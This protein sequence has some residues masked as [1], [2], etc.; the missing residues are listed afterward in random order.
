MTLDII[1]LIAL[2]LIFDFLNGFHDSANSIATIVSTR[3]L[4]PRLARVIGR[5]KWDKIRT[6]PLAELTLAAI[7]TLEKKQGKWKRVAVFPDGRTPSERWWGT[8]VAACL[9]RA[10]IKTEGR[11]IVPHSARHS[12]ASALYAR[13]TQLKTIQEM[14]GH[15]D[16]KTTDIYIHTAADA[17]NEMTK[18]IN[19]ATKKKGK[20]GRMKGKAHSSIPK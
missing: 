19:A 12:L 10:G 5:P 13:G 20:A 15:T 14:L 17:I 16:L 1:F 4:S 9:K 3:V 8:H 2:A 7:E 6:A 18:S 11:N